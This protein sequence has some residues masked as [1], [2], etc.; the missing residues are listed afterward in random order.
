MSA[1]LATD[2][3][4]PVALPAP[5]L[6][7]PLA[8]VAPA[9][10]YAWRRDVPRTAS[11]TRRLVAFGFD[12]VV[13]FA[14][15]WTLT[16]VTATAGFLR[17]PDIEVGGVNVPILGLLWMVSIFELPLL[18]AYFTL[19][20]GTTGRTPGKILLGLRV[21]RTDQG[22][23]GLSDSFLRNLLRLLWVTPF[24]PAF[25][26]L[27]YWSLQST[28]LDQRMGDLAAGTLVVDDRLRER[29]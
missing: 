14:L 17:I 16:F 5:A 26:L 2:A 29:L 7:A 22:T 15:A 8:D 13:I 11:I 6:A 25:V 19:F 12:A 27:D 4:A 9:V 28:E 23:V 3:H 10:A 20:E 18:L 24:G 1:P 21:Q